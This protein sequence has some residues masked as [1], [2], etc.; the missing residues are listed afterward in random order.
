MTSIA[1]LGAGTMGEAILAGLLRS[2]T[3]ASDVVVTTRR[4]ERS[5]ELLA[6][7]GVRTVSTEEAAGADVVVLGV[8]PVDMAGLVEELAHAVTPQSL[9]VSIAAGLP[10]RFYE[11]RLH[12]PVPVVRVMPNTPISVG[13][14]MNVLTA[15]QYA[16]EQHLATVE[17]L[18]APVGRSVRVKETLFDAATALAGSGPAYHF[19]YAEAMVD[20]GVLLGLPRAMA[21]ELVAQTAYGAAA[22]LRDSGRSAAELRDQVTSPGGTTIAALRQLEA[23]G[24]RAAV[25]DALEAARDRSREM[26]AG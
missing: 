16:G 22:M 26:G 2:G 25:F 15:G 18:L 9:L 13:E 3:P 5:A 10:T 6:R 24:L 4:E 8:K 21:R 17:E 7:H 20:A 19:L 1:V 14:A 12:R 23:H 11:E